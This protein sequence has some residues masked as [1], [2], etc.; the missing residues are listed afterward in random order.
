MYLVSYING[1]NIM[2]VSVA[3]FS[4]CV[5]FWLSVLLV[6]GV[7]AGVTWCYILLVVLLMWLLLLSDVFDV[8]K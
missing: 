4:G 3:W 6:S 8:A 1:P 7:A 2:S 5:G